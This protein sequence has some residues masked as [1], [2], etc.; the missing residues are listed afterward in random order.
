MLITVPTAGSKVSVVMVVVAESAGSL[1]RLMRVLGLA[2][3]RTAVRGI[4][5]GRMHGPLHGLG[6][7]GIAM[8]TGRG[9][10]AATPLIFQFI[11]LRIIRVLHDF[12]SGVYQIGDV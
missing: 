10:I 1:P 2:S 12:G 7:I 5:R 9:T 4:S 8:P 6:A 3:D 11:R